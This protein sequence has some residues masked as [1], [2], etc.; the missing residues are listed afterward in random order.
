V[1]F[2]ST[3][4]SFRGF[5]IQANNALVVY[6]PE[7]AAL[8]EQAFQ[9][10][11]DNASPASS[12]VDWFTGN[13][14]S[15]QWH[16]VQI[17]GKPMLKFCFS[18]HKDTDLSMKPV[19]DAIDNAES[20]VFYSIAFLS[21]T[22]SGPVREAVDKLTKRWLFSYGISDKPGNL[23]VKKPD[24][25]VGTVSFAYLQKVTPAPFNSEWSGGAGIH[26]HDKFVVTDFSLPTA[27]VFTGSSNL[28]PS[29][30]KGNGDNL[31]M[32]QDQKVATSYAIEALR[33]F[34]HLHFRVR[35]Q[36]GAKAKSKK[37]TEKVLTLKKPKAIGGEPNWFESYYV[38]KSQ[39]ESD[40]KLFS[41]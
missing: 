21:Q 40:R 8:F 5:F 25:S 19:G 14:I 34:D 16:E 3:N 15:Q 33:I 12:K 28:A 35:M 7:A 23:V 13:P 11:F 37:A 1:L 36:Q 6:A 26:Q 31:V 17:A 32:I 30:E 10:A 41:K 39:A 29:G 22:K 2:G 27:T 20:S 18:T 24:G 38:K 4:F 9:L